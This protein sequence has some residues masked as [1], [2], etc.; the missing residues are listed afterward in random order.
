MYPLSG[1]AAYDRAITLFS[2][3]G[4]LYQ[5][6]YATKAADMGTLGLGMVYKDGVLLAADKRVLSRLVVGGTVEKLFQVD[7][8]IGVVASGIVGDSRALVDYAREVAEKYR[9]TYGEPIPIHVL[10][11]EVAKLKQVYTQY[12]G[13]RP[14]GVVM[15]IG[16]YD[17]SPRL[18]ETV[19]SGALMEYKAEAIGFG[20]KEVVE[21]LEK[22]YKENMKL[23]EAIELAIKALK[24]SLPEE[25]KLTPERVA[26]AYIDK[27]KEMTFLPEKKIAD[28]LG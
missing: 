27:K 28:L 10:A 6:E 21:L 13:I 1:A 3:E 24:V 15:L 23:D 19:P 26:M 14:F 9:F 2:P 25:E 20:K 22:E 5:V 7:K 8:H 18:F 11:R 4:K 12:G 16:G 17:E